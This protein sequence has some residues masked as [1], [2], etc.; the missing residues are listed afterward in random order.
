LCRGW[1]ITHHPYDASKS[2]KKKK[3]EIEFQHTCFLLDGGWGNGQDHW[4]G[5]VGFCRRITPDG[6]SVALFIVLT[7]LPVLLAACGK[8]MSRVL[9]LVPKG[10]GQQELLLMMC[11]EFECQCIVVNLARSRASQAS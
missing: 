3:G 6:I 2:K 11:S 4:L 5:G 8:R 1:H 7:A 9:K 10:I